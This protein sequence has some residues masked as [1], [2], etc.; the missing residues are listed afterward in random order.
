VERSAVGPAKTMM[1]GVS[2]APLIGPVL[3]AML[4]HPRHRFLVLTDSR[5]I[6]L[7]ARKITRGRAAGLPG[8]RGIG[9]HVVAETPIGALAVRR[10]SQKRVF[11]VGLDEEDA[12]QSIE[13]PKQRAKAAERML[14]GFRLLAREDD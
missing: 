12:P 2:L 6:V 7:D 13:V 3:A 1:I 5:L 8:S 9:L 11:R 10:T 4:T 14:E